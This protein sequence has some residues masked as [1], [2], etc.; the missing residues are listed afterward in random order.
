MGKYMRALRMIAKDGSLTADATEALLKANALETDGGPGSGNFGHKGR[1]GQKGGSAGGEGENEG[2]SGGSTG[3]GI[4]GFTKSD[5]LLEKFKKECVRQ[6]T[7]QSPNATYRAC[8]GFLKSLKP[9]TA[10]RFNEP[11]SE[12]GEYDWMV[13]NEDGSYTYTNKYDGQKTKLDES[14]VASDLSTYA[15][16]DKALKDFFEQAP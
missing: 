9:G 7:D 2:S 6:D 5:G 10:F 1:A 8:R 14:D 4:S 3:S 12:T 13:K 15:D 11:N 16:P